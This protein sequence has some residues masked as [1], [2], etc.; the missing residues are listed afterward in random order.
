[1]ERLN[2]EL[3]IQESEI[4]SNDTANQIF[5]EVMHEILVVFL[6]LILFLYFASLALSFLKNI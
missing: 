2:L 4:L 1:M 6:V 3:L 5:G